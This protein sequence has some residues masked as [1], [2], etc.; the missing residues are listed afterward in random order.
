MYKAYITHANGRQHVRTRG[1]SNQ[2][3]V[4]F[5][6]LVS[7]EDYVFRANILPDARPLNALNDG[8][9]IYDKV[10]LKQI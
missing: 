8:G 4:S 2:W 3:R 10:T 9:D 7:N 5:H 6:Q 1:F